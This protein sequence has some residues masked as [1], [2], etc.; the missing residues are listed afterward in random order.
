[1]YRYDECCHMLYVRSSNH[2]IIVTNLGVFL[3]INN[4]K[5]YY[6]VKEAI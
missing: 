4:N 5:Y 6:A 2:L 3:L 1:M